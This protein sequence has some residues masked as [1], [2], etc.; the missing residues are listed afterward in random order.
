MDDTERIIRHFV[1]YKTNMDVDNNATIEKE[2]EILIR[3]S[4]EIEDNNKQQYE[5][6][7]FI[8]H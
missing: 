6:R 7:T 2:V 3:L 5:R 4:M 8:Q 1:M